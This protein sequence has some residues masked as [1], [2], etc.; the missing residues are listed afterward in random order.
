VPKSRQLSI[1]HVGL[2][3]LRT[4][5]CRS[6]SRHRLTHLVSLVFTILTFS[7][8]VEEPWR[9]RL[10]ASLL[11]LLIPRLV[12]PADVSAQVSNVRLRNEVERSS[13]L[14][15]YQL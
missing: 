13:D 10:A 2:C 5:A 11:R 14:L 6:G 9:A 4:V 12:M 8:F 3:I 7:C 15:I 1:S